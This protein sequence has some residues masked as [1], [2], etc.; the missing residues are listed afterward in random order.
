M[1]LAVCSPMKMALPT[2]EAQL[3]KW[4]HHPSRSLDR[5]CR[6]GLCGDFGTGDEKSRPPIFQVAI[7]SSSSFVDIASSASSRSGSDGS[8]SSIIHLARCAAATISTPPRSE[9][10]TSEL[11]SRPHLV[12]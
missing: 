8:P 1:L 11:Q 2:D 12:C 9:E 7:R 10:H 4:L 3:A 5:L 6:S